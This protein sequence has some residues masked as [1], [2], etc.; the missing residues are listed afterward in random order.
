MILDAC[1]KSS[2]MLFL[3]NKKPL[4]DAASSPRACNIKVCNFQ[5]KTLSFH[6]MSEPNCNIFQILGF[7]ELGIFEVQIYGFWFLYIESK[8][9][10]FDLQWVQMA[11]YEV[12]RVTAAHGSVSGVYVYKF[13]QPRPGRA[14]G[15]MGGRP[16]GGRTNGRKDVLKRKY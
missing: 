4:R 9:T 10:E 7:P 16:D 8:I 2:G 3:P 15:R 5:S 11:R 6:C 13:G 12:I 1:P 14:D